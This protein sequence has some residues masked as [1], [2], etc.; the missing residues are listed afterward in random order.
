M[1]LWI[2]IWVLLFFLLILGHEFGHFIAAKKSGVK[3][4]EFGI[5]IPPK[6]CTLFKDKSGTNYT[7][8]LL[9]LWWFVRLKGEDPQ[10]EEEFNARDSFVKAKLHKKIIILIAGVAMNF[11]IA[12]GIFTAIFTIGTKPVIVLPE[13]AIATT[14]HSYLMPTVDFLDSKWLISGDILETPALILNVYDGWLG[15]SL[16]LQSWDIIKTINQNTVNTQNLTKVLKDNIWQEIMLSYERSGEIINKKTKCPEDNCLL[17][18]AIKSS[19]I[20]TLSIKFPFITAAW[21]ALSE[22]KVQ[23]QITLS[24]LW[25]LGKWLISFDGTKIKGSLSK[26][27]WPVWAVKFGGDLLE[28][29]WIIPYLGF[30][31]II[32]LALAILN[33]L[34]IPALDGGRLLGVLIQVIWKLKPEKYFTVEN[35][36]NIIFFILLLGLW[37]Y[38]ILKDLVVAW[39]VNIPFIG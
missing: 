34:P 37:V 13:N 18:I 23:T 39:G 29:K 27:S 20:E 2:I 16:G 10:N 4:L 7:L 19:N 33:I 15:S 1:I 12:R 36:I 30:A 17:E 8:N 5:G 35:Y 9:P 32:S 31:G 6:V 14:S 25:R 11:V 26:L 21:V 24:A 3:V 22:I 38:I 28:R